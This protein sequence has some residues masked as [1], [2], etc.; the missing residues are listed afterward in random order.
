MAIVLKLSGVISPIGLMN[1]CLMS[2]EHAGDIVCETPLLKVQMSW[3]MH[4]S[5]IYV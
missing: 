4:S 5:S 2:D 3:I 1:C